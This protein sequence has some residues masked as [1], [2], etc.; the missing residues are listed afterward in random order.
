MGAV[1]GQPEEIRPVGA[2]GK[3]LQLVQDRIRAG[4]IRSGITKRRL[5]QK[6]QRIL[7]QLLRAQSLHIGIAEAVILKVWYKYLIP[8]TAD[9]DIR[10][11][12]VCIFAERI[13]PEEQGGI[14]REA[15]F[16][17][18]FPVA[19]HDLLP[20]LPMNMQPGNAGSIDAKVEYIDIFPNILLQRLCIIRRRFINEREPV[21]MGD[22]Y[23]LDDPE[24]F[25]GRCRL[26]HPLPFWGFTGQGPLPAGII[27]VQRVPPRNLQPGIASAAHAQIVEGNVGRMRPEILIRFP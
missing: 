22:R 15:H 23:R 8:A 27:K 20:R 10:L 26:Q 21:V 12:E 4:K 1:C 7:P 17:I 16:I 18:V 2:E 11:P 14:D 24:R 19:D 6:Q 9:I 13:V 5:F 25:D 3:F